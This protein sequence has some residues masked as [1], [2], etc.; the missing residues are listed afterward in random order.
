MQ[1]VAKSRRLR[2]TW[3][4]TWDDTPCDFAC[5]HNGNS[6]GRIYRD[7][8][9]RT[10]E[11]RWF[12]CANGFIESRG[13]WLSGSGYARSKMEAAEEVEAAYFRALQR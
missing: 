10:M 1:Q 13:V 9:P 6:V 4:R 7:R 5:T 2:L 8:A 12:W 11:P 3:K